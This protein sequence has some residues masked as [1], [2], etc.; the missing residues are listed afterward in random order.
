[1]FSHSKDYLDLDDDVYPNGAA[2]PLSTEKEMTDLT[3]M[4]E[5]TDNTETMVH[6]KAPASSVAIP[7]KSSRIDDQTSGGTGDGS[8]V[9]GKVDLST[10]VISSTPG[11]AFKP[12]GVTVAASTQSTFGS[13]KSTLL[14]G[15]VAAPPSFSF[16]NKVAF[17]T[18]LTAVDAPSK[19]LSKP[20][21]IFSFGDKVV[22]AK[23]SVADA[24]L[25][26][27][28]ANE[29]VD[30]VPQ[31]P[32]TSSSSVGAES[33]GLKFGASSDSKLGNSVR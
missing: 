28:G 32:L 22:S 1:M 5:K 24:P 11:L 19:E 15:S 29:N 17:S 31:M 20:D 6:E 23:E 4:A 27:F 26:N 3:R 12:V 9:G 14:N 2:S 7:F 21:P 8:I 25:Y 18:E 10:S 13:D 16:G 33:T 30:K